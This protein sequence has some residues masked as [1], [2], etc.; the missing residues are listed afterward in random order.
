MKNM[1]KTRTCDC[2]GT[3]AFCSDC[4]VSGK[5]QSGMRRIQA[6]DDKLSALSN[7]LRSGG[8]D[9]EWIPQGDPVVVC[10]VAVE[11]GLTN[12]VREYLRTLDELVEAVHAE[13]S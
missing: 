7:D 4:G 12:K 6:L 2:Y 1:M 3:D 8:V 11:K 13:V 9:P 5:V 10:F